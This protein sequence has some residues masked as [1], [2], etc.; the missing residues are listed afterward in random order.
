M[1]RKSD[2]LVMSDTS[3]Y[4]ATVHPCPLLKLSDECRSTCIGI[5]S[6]MQTRT[7]PPQER[8]SVAAEGSENEN[9]LIGDLERLARSRLSE[10]RAR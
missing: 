4:L 2:I 7:G 3:T 6:T 1:V 10:D 9:S 5:D 8:A